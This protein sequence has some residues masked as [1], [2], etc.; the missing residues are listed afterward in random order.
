MTAS[1]STPENHTPQSL[2]SG[3]TILVVDDE[4]INLAVLSALLEPPHHVKVAKSGQQALQI[5]EKPEKPDL[6]LLDVMMPELSGFDVCRML[7]ANPLTSKIPVLFVTAK[8]DPASEE[9]GLRLGAVDYIHK[10][11][12]PALVQARVAAHLSLHNQQ[13]ELEKQVQARTQALSETRL[14][15]IQQLGRAA[16]YRDN[17]TG[18]HV[19][20]MANYAM[21]LAKATGAPEEW[22]NLLY[23]A[24]PMHDVGKIG[25]PDHILLKPGKLNEEELAIMH[26]HSQ[27]GADIIGDTAGSDLFEMAANIALYHHEK[28]DGSG[29]PTGISGEDIPLEARIASLA[30]VFDALV[31]SRPYKK[32]W[33]VEDALAHIAAESGRSFDPTLAALFLN[34]APQFEAVRREYT[35]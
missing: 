24:A 5:L 2:N 3:Y 19:I 6:I 20:R 35:D 30:D 10:P 13:I 9:E 18:S 17:E 26:T 21:M 12:V 23:L 15:L 14:K 32:P 8:A 34:L 7:K 11:I 28:W 31:S 25:I 4:P 29:Y 22:V 33:T 16:E 1:N 27:I